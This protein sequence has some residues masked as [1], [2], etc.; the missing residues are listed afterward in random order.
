MSVQR[1]CV[2]L[3]ECGARRVRAMSVRF[4]VADGDGFVC[5]DYAFGRSLIRATIKS[6][7]ANSRSVNLINTA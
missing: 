1:R 5:F 3:R 7:S 6:T 2:A 4:R